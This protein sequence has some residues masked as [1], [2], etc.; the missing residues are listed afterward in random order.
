MRFNDR[1]LFSDELLRF[2]WTEIRDETSLL[3][4]DTIESSDRIIICLFENIHAY[5]IE[6][7]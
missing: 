5:P 7:L 3:Y 1:M 4:S 6:N 2:I